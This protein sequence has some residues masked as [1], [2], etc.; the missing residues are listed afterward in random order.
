V[1]RQYKIKTVEETEAMKE[2]LKAARVVALVKKQAEKKA[3]AEA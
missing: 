3:P 2:R 1:W